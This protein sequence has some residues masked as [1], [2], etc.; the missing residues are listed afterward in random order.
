MSM[1]IWVQSSYGNFVL[2]FPLILSAYISESITHLA[3]S[4]I[5]PLSSLFRVCVSFILLHLC[6][7]C[8][9]FIDCAKDYCVK[10]HLSCLVGE[11]TYFSI[12]LPPHYCPEISL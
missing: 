10:S 8:V 4:G 6:C 5:F 3:T 7:V 1:N 9:Y 2:F 11:L 12:L